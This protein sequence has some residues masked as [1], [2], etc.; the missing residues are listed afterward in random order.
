MTPRIVLYNPRS[1]STGKKILP[2]SI[3]ALGAV[4]EGRYEFSIVDGNLSADPLGDIRGALRQGANVVA[5]TVMPGPQL[6]RAFPH[7][8]ALKEEFPGVLVVWGGYFPTLHAS[9]CLN[10]SAVD[11][12]VRGHGELAFL[13]LL[14]RFE[15]GEDV[16]GVKG[17]A[18]RDGGGTVVENPLPP[19]PHPDTLPPFPYHRI[20]MPQ[21][22]RRTFL[23]SRTMPHHSSYGC[24]FLCNFCAVVN[25]VNGRWLAQSA[26]RVAKVAEMY[27]ERW[28]VNA[29]EFHDN[30]FFT[31]EARVAE[32]SGRIAP[33]GLTWWGEGRIDT[34]LKY[35]DRTWRSMRDAGLKSVFLGAESASAEALRR[36]DKGGTLTPEKTIEIAAK[37]RQF[38]IIPE[39]SFMVGNPPDPEA[40]ASAT[41]EFIRRVKK[42]NPG[43]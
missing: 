20:D 6:S 29:I 5:V 14:E 16:S 3:L 31:H 26:E 10:S 18:Y 27:V 21:Y 17:L 13:E 9:A 42:I 33:L 41:L 40:D 34:L 1:N 39:F 38:G 2:M 37:M 32:I 23:G 7:S 25:M 43:Q 28:Q 30:N 11:Y 22:V 8:R 4:L 36:M 12:V 35:S 19:I 15:S 24:P